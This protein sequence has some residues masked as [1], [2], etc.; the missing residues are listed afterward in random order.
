MARRIGVVKGK[1]QKLSP[2][3]K[4]FAMGKVNDVCTRLNRKNYSDLKSEID[5]F[6]LNT[7]EDRPAKCVEMAQ[8]I[9]CDSWI[10]G[11][12]QAGGQIL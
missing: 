9:L 4:T 1:I 8:K 5:R 12:N 7:L 3:D 2:Y 11:D 10:V 6:E